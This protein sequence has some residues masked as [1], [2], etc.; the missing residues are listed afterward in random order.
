MDYHHLTAHRTPHPP[1]PATTKYMYLF[2]N[3]AILDILFPVDAA[4]ACTKKSEIDPTLGIPTCMYRP[5]DL[6]LLVRVHASTRLS[7]STQRASSDQGTR[8]FLVSA[9]FEPGPYMYVPSK[10]TSYRRESREENKP[11]WRKD[12][13]GFAR[14][15]ACAAK[16][17]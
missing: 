11:L 7:T 9:T 14:L 8:S 10:S 3:R 6:D 17:V 4:P 13:K 12:C 2:L 15:C 5:L 1:P 16:L